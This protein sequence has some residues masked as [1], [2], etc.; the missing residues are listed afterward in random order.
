MFIVDWFKAK[1]GNASADVAKT[2]LSLD[3][4]IDHLLKIVVGVLLVLIHYLTQSSAFYKLIYY[5][6]LSVDLGKTTGQSDR[7]VL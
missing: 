3:L 2:Y 1:Q 7:I 4:K 6:P 5:Y